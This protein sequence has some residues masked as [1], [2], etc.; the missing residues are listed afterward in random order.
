[1]NCAHPRAKLHGVAAGGVRVYRCPDCGGEWRGEDPTPPE[2]TPFAVATDAAG[3]GAI[4]TDEGESVPVEVLTK[5]S[6]V[7]PITS[8]G[9]APN[10]VLLDAIQRIDLAQTK[11]VALVEVDADGIPWTTWSRG[12]VAHALAAASALTR[13][14][15]EALG[16][17]RRDDYDDDDPR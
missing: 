4:Q 12:P 10:Q 8:G 13:D 3:G 14:A 2:M 5:P 6:N 16:E 9:D 15:Q 1:M 17:I 7:V 11:F